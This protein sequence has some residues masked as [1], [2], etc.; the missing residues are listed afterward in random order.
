[1]LLFNR[2]FFLTILFLNTFY[3]VQAELIEEIP[4]D[5][6][7]TTSM[8][9]TTDSIL[10]KEPYAESID[11]SEVSD[12]IPIEKF[13]YAN[14]PRYTMDGSLPN[15]TTKIKPIPAI[16]IGGVYAGIFLVQHYGQMNTIWKDQGPFKFQED[17][18]YA[19]YADKIGHFFGAYLSSYVISES[20]I[21]AG[22]SWESS[23]IWG[24]CMGFLY[25]AYVEVLDGFGINWGFCWSDFA[26][27]VAGSAFFVA[28]Y[29][30]PYLQYITPKFI[31]YPAPWF[32]EKH[33]VPSEMFID[34]YSSHTLFFSLNI[35]N[36]LPKSMKDYWPEWLEL[37]FGYAA[38]NLCD[39]LHPNDY[40]CDPTRSQ[41]I[42]SDVWGNP[43]FIVALD[44]NL[45]K[46]IP[47]S[48]PFLNWLRQSLNYF[49]LPSPAIEFGSE[50]KFFLLYPFPINIGNVRF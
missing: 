40:T 29:Y 8:V 33:R 17:G 14:N 37:S 2:V 28:Q 7:K 46:L 6:S 9:I 44:Y 1:M 24:G 32:G 21:L 3:F 43:K 42:Y 10:Q 49:K 5:N 19:L 38:R 35:H 13:F 12:Y 4:Q 47:D 22:F 31:Y 30:I 11:S 36:L 18:R 34:D 25:E 45:V 39:P 48:V 41:Q 16:I 50:T 27:D 20:L 15:V 23:T 26:A